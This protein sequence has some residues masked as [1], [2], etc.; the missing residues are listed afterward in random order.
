MKFYFFLQ[1]FASRPAQ[2][3]TP[4]AHAPDTG[5]SSVY[6]IINIDS[7]QIIII[8]NFIM[9]TPNFLLF[10][11]SL[12]YSQLWFLNGVYCKNGKCGN[13]SKKGHSGSATVNAL[14]CLDITHSTLYKF[15]NATI[16]ILLRWQLMMISTALRTNLKANMSLF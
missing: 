1:P 12:Y 6:N 8:F 7:D 16:G 10:V 15:G 14:I 2:P 5:V 4:S 13:M 11:D 3:T 9:R